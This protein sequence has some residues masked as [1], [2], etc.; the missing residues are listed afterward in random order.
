M[1]ESFFLPPAVN[2]AISAMPITAPMTVQT[3]ALRA[4]GNSRIRNALTEKNNITDAIKS[5]ITFP[6]LLSPF[7]ILRIKSQ[8]K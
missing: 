8:T 1:T 4:S 6:A 2:A 3:A 7:T 5:T